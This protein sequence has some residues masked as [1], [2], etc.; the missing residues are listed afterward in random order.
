M[1]SIPNIFFAC[2]AL[3]ILT[4]VGWVM[5]R[6]S[7]SRGFLACL[8]FGLLAIMSLRAQAMDIRVCMILTVFLCAGLAVYLSPRSPV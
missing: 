7:P 2:I 8:A 5:R 4:C 3:Q 1:T 6:M